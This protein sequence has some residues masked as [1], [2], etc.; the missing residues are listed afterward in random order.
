[1]VVVQDLEQLT[2]DPD[3]GT[4]SLRGK[5]TR[6]VLHR[7]RRLSVH[8]LVWW[9]VTG[10]LPRHGEL[11]RLDAKLP[12][13]YSNLVLTRK[14][15]GREG[16][17]QHRRLCNRVR[18]GNQALSRQVALESLKTYLPLPEISEEALTALCVDLYTQC[19]HMTLI[20]LRGMRSR[21]EQQVC[22][23]E[24]LETINELIKR[25]T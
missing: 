5:A 16:D 10:Y 21:L 7:Y 24:E 20:E 14:G 2:I 4:V 22:Y 15:E 19:V 13:S 17:L 9:C 8:Q 23:P 11:H 1:M 6:L 12:P 3:A 25:K 18:K